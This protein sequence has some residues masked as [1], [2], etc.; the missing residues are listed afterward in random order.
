[1]ASTSTNGFAFKVF[2][3]NRG[4]DETYQVRRTPGGWHVSNT[5]VSG[6]CDKRGIPHLSD[7][8][9]HTNIDYSSDVG[10]SFEWLWSEAE[11]HRLSDA[12]LQD[13]LEQLATFV[14]TVEK[15]DLDADLLE[16]AVGVRA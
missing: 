4:G 3:R 5:S 16:R 12:D 10:Q 9:K 7:A 2:S 15:G 1:M 8:L 14:S 6:D 13:A 11:Q